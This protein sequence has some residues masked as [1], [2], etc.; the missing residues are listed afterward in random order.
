LTH[1]TE[2]ILARRIEASHAGAVMRLAGN[3]ED[4]RGRPAG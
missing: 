3:I 4:G 2:T 1:F